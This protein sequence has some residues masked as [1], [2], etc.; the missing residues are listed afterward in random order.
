MLAEVDE[1]GD[2]GDGVG[3]EAVADEVGGR[4]VALDIGFDEAVEELIGGERVLVCLVLAE[5]CARRLFDGADGDED[6]VAVDVAGEFPDA[7]FGE[8]GDGSK[9]A[10]HVAVEGA[11]ADGEFGLVARGEQEGVVV[12]GVGHEE[13]AADA[14]L[15]VLFGEP[16]GLVLERGLQGVSER[17]EGGLDGDG[18]GLDAEVVR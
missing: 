10:A 17:D 5:L 2:A 8:V 3:V 9:R 13:D 16:V 4:A 1:A 15:E 12:V 11:V 6:S 14:G 7:P 18:V